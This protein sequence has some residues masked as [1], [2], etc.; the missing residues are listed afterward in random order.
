MNASFNLLAGWCGFVAGAASGAALGLF[1]CRADFL[2]GYDSWRRR[3]LRLG[4]IACF[5]MGILN[6]LFALSVR[7]C[8][9]EPRLEAW[10]SVAWLAA[11]VAMPVCCALAAWRQ[12]LRHLFPIPVIATFV[13]IGALLLGW[14]NNLVASL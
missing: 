13:G 6:I 12:P 11:L 1:F 9:I 14:W 10:A 4:H 7:A 3:L 5:G 2:G 8:P